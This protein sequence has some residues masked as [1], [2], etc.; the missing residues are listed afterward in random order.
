MSDIL[1][2]TG[3]VA[4]NRAQSRMSMIDRVRLALS[5]TV[6]PS[7]RPSLSTL[8]W[9]LAVVGVIQFIRLGR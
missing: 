2:P 6:V 8:A 9:L 7:H 4:A 1:S 5:P 3:E